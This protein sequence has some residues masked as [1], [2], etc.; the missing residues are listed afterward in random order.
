MIKKW[1][2]ELLQDRPFSTAASVYICECTGLGTQL[3]L[4]VNVGDS[5]IVICILLHKELSHG[6]I[7]FL[8]QDIP[9]MCQQIE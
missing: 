6:D 4:A 9:R 1:T 5:L 3:F 2:P 8:L 7:I